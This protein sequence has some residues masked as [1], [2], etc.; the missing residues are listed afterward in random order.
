M[1]LGLGVEAFAGA[2]LEGHVLQFA[3]AAGIADRAVERVVAEQQFDGRLAGLRDFRRFSD[4]DLAFGN[5]GGAGGLEL[6]H[7]FLPDDAHAAGCL[8][9]EAGV[10]A[11]GWDLDAGFAAGF[12]EQRPRGS[13]QLLSIDCEGYVWH[14]FDPVIS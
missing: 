14:W 11:E 9:A 5:R 10:I 7:F 1:V 3:F 4:E 2:V 12:D 6:G 8:Q 13:R